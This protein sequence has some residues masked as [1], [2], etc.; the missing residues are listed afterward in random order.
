MLSKQDIAIK[1]HVL[2]VS[3]ASLTR[4]GIHIQIPIFISA[5]LHAQKCV[6]PNFPIVEKS[7][8]SSHSATP[9]A[10]HAQWRRESAEKPDPAILAFL[11][12]SLSPSLRIW[13]SSTGLQ[14]RLKGLLGG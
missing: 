3:A 6:S 14:M 5:I 13:G 1:R 11:F 7:S 9:Y 2:N 8:A 10:F 12:A 4:P